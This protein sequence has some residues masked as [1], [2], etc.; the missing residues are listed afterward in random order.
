SQEDQSEIRRGKNVI[1]DLVERISRELNIT[2]C[3]ICGN[4]L[5]IDIWPWEEIGLS[6]LEIIKWKQSKPQSPSVRERKQEQWNLK[7]KVT[8]Q[9]CIWSKE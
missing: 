5:M 8:G 9:E 7:M 3:W 4:T 6:P 2:N 1:V